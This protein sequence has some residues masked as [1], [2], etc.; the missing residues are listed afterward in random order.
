M[1]TIIK[2]V[3]IDAK[4]GEVWDALE[5][6]GALHTRLVPGFVTACDFDGEARNI[7]FSNGTSAREHL[8]TSDAANRRLVYAIIGQRM[9]HYS[10][11]AQ[12]FDDGGKAR[13]TWTVDVLPNELAPYISSQMDL[14][15]AAMQ[16]AFAKKAA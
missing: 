3:L 9:K 4:P 12:V 6:F 13:L 2:D 8:V 5:D 15:A 10:A 11:S 16:E 7:T 14:G 1:A